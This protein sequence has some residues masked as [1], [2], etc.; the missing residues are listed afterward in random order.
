MAYS[1]EKAAAQYRAER[2]SPLSVKEAIA[3]LYRQY[4]KKRE[5]A[6]LDAAAVAT[7]VHALFLADQMDMSSVTPQM[8]EAFSLAYPNV[9]FA[10]LLERS[11]T[12]IEG[13]LAAWKGKYFEVLVRDEL[14]AGEW[15]GDIHLNPG[16]SVVLAESTVQP[17]WDLQIVDADGV[18]DQALQL[19]TTESLSYVKEAL[20]RYPD[21]D[22]LT[23]DEVMD[24]G[25]NAVQNIFSS[26]FSDQAIEETIYA[27]M[28]SLLD[29][30]AGELIETL[31]PSLPFV[32]I[33]VSESHRVLVGR[34]TFGI[35]MQ[36][37][38]SRSIK[39]GASI[40]VGT[41]VAFINGGWLSVPA[42]F[43]TSMG[44]ERYQATNRSVNTLN[45]R[46]ALIE[47]LTQS[48]PSKDN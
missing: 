47:N 36:Q 10:S 21:I 3:D 16:Q 33:A 30:P 43:L 2:T 18:V 15:V 32:L 34:Q 37:G 45:G 27:P 40:G 8:S 11:P 28:E 41:L 20:E 24:A 23:V 22:V 26:G 39:S 17:G 6:L 35:A 25:G 7:A 29:S 5:Q 12:E 46:I 48:L 19:K 42:S 13:F 38:L 14:N 44:I 9:E 4:I 31:L 1:L